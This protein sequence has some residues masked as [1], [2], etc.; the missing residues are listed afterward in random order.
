MGGMKDTTVPPSSLFLKDLGFGV[1][2]FEFQVQG[3]RLKVQVS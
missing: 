2:G 1:S 3:P